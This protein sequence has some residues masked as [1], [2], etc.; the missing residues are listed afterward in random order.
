[1]QDEHGNWLVCC[2]KGCDEK[3]ISNGLCVN[4]LRFT[5]KY[6]SPV[7]RKM[8][9]YLWKRLPYEERFWTWVRK[10]DGDG[11][12]TWQ[13]GH[14]KDGYGAFRAEH[15]GVIYTRAHRYSYALHK[16][17][18]PSLLEVCHTCDNR[19]CVR[20]D[21]LFPGTSRENHEDKMRKGRHRA[22]F[23]EEHPFARLT[24]EQAKV[25]LTDPRPHTQIANQYG[26]H[27]Q[28][29]RSLKN[30][31]SWPHLGTEK[32]VKSKRISPRRG[33]SDKVTPE[34]VREIRASTERGVDLAARFGLKPQDITDIRKRRS[35]SHIE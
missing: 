27:V 3:P 12:W 30:R 11:C 16:G 5:Q 26:V 34:I 31:D 22:R 4:H 23:G 21:H 6:G 14:D 1:M 2:I 32:G 7:A 20:P 15:N 8:A 24:E 29:I 28:T 35:W 25:I 19:S 10:S 13:A 9:L 18:I 17:N 33:K